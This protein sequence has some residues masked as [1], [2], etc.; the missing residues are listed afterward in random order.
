MKKRVLLT[1]GVMLFSFIAISGSPKEAQAGS[2]ADTY[3]WVGQGMNEARHA[4]PLVRGVLGIFM[5]QVSGGYQG[6]P[7]INAPFQ[8]VP[9]PEVC[10]RVYVYDQQACASGYWKGV[11]QY[12]QRKRRESYRDGYRLGNQY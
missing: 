7:S 3:F 12:E 10:T 9:V 6:H 2:K 5:P 11:R 4:F 1:I 8:F